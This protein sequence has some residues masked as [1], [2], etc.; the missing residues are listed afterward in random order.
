MDNHLTT[1]MSEYYQ[2]NVVPSIMLYGPQM[3]VANW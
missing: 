1:I 3:D 2:N